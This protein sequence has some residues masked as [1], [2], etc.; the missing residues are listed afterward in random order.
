[1]TWVLLLIR[2]RKAR[3]DEAN[4]KEAKRFVVGVTIALVLLLA[5]DVL[6][7]IIAQRANPIIPPGSKIEVQSPEDEAEIK[8]VLRDSQMYESLVIYERPK[9]FD[10]AV[11][12]KFWLSS[13]K[14]GKA[15]EKI[16][17]SIRRLLTKKWHYGEE[18]RL[19]ML[20]YKYCRIY[21]PGNSAEVGTTEKWYLPVYHENGSRILEKNV[22]LGPLDVDY[23]FVKIDGRWLLQSN[24]APYA[25]Q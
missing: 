2:F 6:S 21:Y 12:N 3:N 20:E 16:E 24:N 25:R 7:V 22:F 8:R 15:M 9:D 11:L 18:S 14:G 19:E 10:R 23:F 1:M 4:R 13:E 17:A 5:I